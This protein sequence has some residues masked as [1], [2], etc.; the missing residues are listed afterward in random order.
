LHIA[1]AM[2]SMGGDDISLWDEEDQ[3]YYDV[4]HLPDQKSELLKI[5]SMVGL[6]PLFAVEILTPDL[7]E[8]LPDFKRRVE[9]VLTNRPDLAGLISRWYE[10]GRGENRLLAILRGHRMKM[11]MKRMFDESEFLSDFG[12]R[13][14]SKYHKENP[15]QF[16]INGDILQVDYTPAESTGSMFGG[17]SNW[18]GPIWFPMNF[19]LI[20]SLLKFQ[21]YYGNDYEV[22]YPTDSGNM[23]SIK[24]AALSLSQ[25]LI[26]L[27]RQDKNGNRPMYEKYE[28]M[29]SDPNFKDLYQF[30]E[31][32]DG[33]TGKG[34]GAAHQTGWTGLISELI[35]IVSQAKKGVLPEMI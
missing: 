27:F 7:L 24:Q 12:I 18:R 26:D 35:L 25:R 17:N 33:D 13:S 23:M 10:A 34:L 32:F 29:Q 2:Q 15:Y 3:F 1:G 28:K 21:S 5:R 8:K 30:Y 14:L 9:W 16:R 31:F 19:L 4:L 11:I 6:I 22:E 20:D